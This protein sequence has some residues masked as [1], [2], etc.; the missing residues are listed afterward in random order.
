MSSSL[1]NMNHKH[2]KQ[3]ALSS[4]GSKNGAKI[5]RHS[6]STVQNPLN[7]WMFSQSCTLVMPTLISIPLFPRL[8]FPA[9][10]QQQTSLFSHVCF[11]HLSVLKEMRGTWEQAHLSRM[12]L[13]RVCV[14]LGEEHLT[15]GGDPKTI[16]QHCMSNPEHSCMHTKGSPHAILPNS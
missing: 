13:G 6:G 3:T 12:G 1:Y 10:F 2:D 7:T 8:T 16:P 11:I 5:Y 9:S 14:A 15:E 4:Y